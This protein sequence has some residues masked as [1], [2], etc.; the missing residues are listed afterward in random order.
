[1]DRLTYAERGAS[2]VQESTPVQTTFE[3]IYPK[4]WVS[5]VGELNQRRP[6]T[7]TSSE[8]GSGAPIPAYNGYTGVDQLDM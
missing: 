3:A 7:E 1:M 6:H 5:S 8:V 4:A 2:K